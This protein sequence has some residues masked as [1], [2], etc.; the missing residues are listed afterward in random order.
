MTAEQ[1][2]FLSQLAAHLGMQPC[3]A[4]SLASP[5][6]FTSPAGQTCRL[7][8]HHGEAAVRPEALLPMSAADVADARSRQLMLA[9]AAVLT[10]F[11]WQLGVSLEGLLQL[12]CLF[13]IDRPD[14][15]ATAFELANGIGIAVMQNLL[16]ELPRDTGSAFAH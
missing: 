16:H 6:L 15:A 14:D 9:Q 11:G 3:E 5:R 1:I 13:W 8:L 12:S 7:H 2:E 10:E 4:A